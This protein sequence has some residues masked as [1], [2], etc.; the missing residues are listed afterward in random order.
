[1]VTRIV[2]PSGSTKLIDENGE[3]TAQ[4]RQ[5]IN[6]INNQS[7]IIGTGSPDGVVEASAGSR[8]MDDAGVTGSILYIKQKDSILGD[9]TKGWVLT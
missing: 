8:Y 3:A 2:N 7:L 6:S 5:W 4:F 1:M 9:K